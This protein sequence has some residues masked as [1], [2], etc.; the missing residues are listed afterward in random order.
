MPI[1]Y[2]SAPY[3]DDYD[4]TKKF[5]TILFRPGRAV[6][7]RELTQLQTL[8]QAQ[9]E[10]FGNGIY[11]EGSFVTPP[12]QTYD[13][14]YSFIKLQDTYNS[15]DADDVIEDLVG[16][17]LIG[18]TTGIRAIVVN[19]TL[20]TDTDPPTL[21]VKYLSSGTNNVTLTFSNN[22]I[23]TNEASTT[24]VRA[25]TTNSAGFGTAFSVGE[26]VIFAKG[27]FLFVEEQTFIAEKYGAVG[28]KIIGFEV[29]ESLVDSDQ[30][31]TLLDPA[32]GT[33]NYFAPGAD[34][35]K[36]SLT[37]AE[38]EFTP[39]PLDEP[40]FIEIIRVQ[41]GL[42]ISNVTDPRLSILGD[43]LARRTFDESGNYIVNPFGVSLI[44]HLLE[45]PPTTPLEAVTK[46][47]TGLYPAANGGDESLFVV[48]VTPGKAY[49]KGYEVDDIPTRY[50]ELQKARDFA[51]VNSGVVATQLS[52]F[53]RVDNA[54]SIPALNDIPVVEIYDRYNNVPGTANGSKVGTARIRG[55]EYTS[56]NVQTGTAVFNLHIFD[57]QMDAGKSFA[58][59]AKQVFSDNTGYKD[60]TAN[61]TPTL[62]QLSG[63]ASFTNASNTITG[64]GTRFSTQTAVGDTITIGGQRFVVNAVAND[65]SLTSV[66]NAIGTASGQLVFLNTSVVNDADK[67]SFLIK[68]PFDVIKTV[69]PTNTETVYTTKRNYSRTLSAGA[70]T[71]TAGT[72][73]TFA[74][75]SLDNYQ[76][77]LT[78]GPAGA[79]VPLDSSKITRGGSPTG[80]TLTVDVS[81][82]GYTNQTVQIYTTVNKTNSASLRKSKTLQQNATVDFTAKAD[83]Q[84]TTLSLGKADGVRLVSVRMA[85][86]AFGSSFVTAGSTD[87]T[88]RYTFDNGQKAT[89]Y[90]LAKIVLKPGSPKPTNP[91][92]VTFDYFTHGSGDYFS[93]NS[94]S[95]IN[96]KD[97][98]TVTIDDKVINLRDYLD[99]RPRINDAGTAFTSTGGST[100][101]FIDP[102]V[103]LTTDYQYYLPRIDVVGIDQNSAYYVR[104]GISSLNPVEPSIPSDILSLFVLRQKPYVFD[105]QN[106][107]DVIRVENRRYTMKDISK[108]DNR[109]KTLE[110]YTSL[111]LLERDAQQAQIK[112]AL[113]FERFKNGFLVDSFTGHGV[114]DSIENPDYAVS[115]NYKNKEASPLL[116][117]NFLNLSEAATTNAQRTSNNYIITNDLITLPY[118]EV[119]FLDNKFSSKTE[120]LNPF[121]VVVFNGLITLDPPGDLW[122]EDSRAPEIIVDQ[123][124][125]YESLTSASLIKRDGNNIFGSINDIEQFRNGIPPDPSDLPDNL[126]SLADLIGSVSPSTTTLALSGKEVIKNVSVIPKMRS[127]DIS[128]TARGMRPNT[129]LYA[130]FDEINV[131][132]FCRLNTANVVQAISSINA[133]VTTEADISN[134]IDLFL[135]LSNAIVE[136]R[137][138]PLSTDQ[139]GSISGVFSY[140]SSSLNFSTGKKLFR[141]TNSVDNNREIEGTFAEQYF[142]SD[143]L[144]RE[145]ADEILRPPPPPPPPAPAPNY[146]YYDYGYDSGWEAP[147]IVVAPPAGGTG[148]GINPTPSVVTPPPPT[149]LEIIYRAIGGRAPD[150]KGYDFWAKEF[151]KTD[152]F[153][154]E[155]VDRITWG[156][157]E[158]NDLAGIGTKNLSFALTSTERAFET[159]VIVASVQLANLGQPVT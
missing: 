126:K 81:S 106:D 4:Q 48:N 77:V 46:P 22:E 19:H 79:F 47:R 146:S 124:G 39:G 151:G 90:D 10:R 38:R 118:T 56:G 119:V 108:I 53:I 127:V 62:V 154:K 133:N 94:Y 26:C 36:I 152:N 12:K 14:N 60:F 8:L 135:N 114:G 123:T 9:I 99:F 28:S 80:T 112:D 34:R 130:F 68:F 70:V 74:P 29:S 93:V 57:L 27:Y 24:S 87:I 100:T 157:I 45:D 159:S 5:Y 75:F 35:T 37:L 113:G 132:N 84:A 134:N 40:N 20:S 42:V 144:Q 110:Y 31:E 73:E 78:S 86:V 107:I 128:F 131:T 121:N 92:R 101:E 32:I 25:I 82:D 76:V 66:T 83:A 147:V 85:N 91:I 61:I 88:N 116:K 30:D 109:V 102:E 72:D 137:V 115:V 122:F 71:I 138:T 140:Q 104:K 89:Y 95:G 158:N 96:Y 156:F 13:L 117:T 1:T 148:T 64:V 18:Q 52:S 50:I 15:V 136:T 142:F 7:A 97:I 129:R 2:P 3:H 49:I 59:D 43:T 98:P 125:S 67:D 120:N 105:L 11:K 54:N 103:D 145:I 41:N 6:Q 23:I 141:L 58:R 139:T 17:I 150:A 143:G 16:Q 149:G 111:S 155:E 44:E 21:Y 33:F 55:M 69:D 65:V 63:T 153:T 51:N